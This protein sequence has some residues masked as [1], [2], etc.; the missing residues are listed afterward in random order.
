VLEAVTYRY[1]GH[2]VADAG[3]AYRSREE[4]EEH[5]R[6]DPLV[7]TRQLLEARGVPAAGLDA[8][9]AEAEEAVERAVAYAEADAPP[10]VDRLAAGVYADGSE[11][12]FERMRPGSPFGEAELVFAGGLGK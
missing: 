1:R 11:E 6:E 5:R 3:L 10:A 4:I 8:L 7:S 2:S 9:E 12:Q